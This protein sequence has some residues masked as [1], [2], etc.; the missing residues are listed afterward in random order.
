MQNEINL[1]SNVE[2]LK[3]EGQNQNNCDFLSDANLFWGPKTTSKSFY[4]LCEDLF[5]HKN[6]S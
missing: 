1:G 4:F 6:L 2:Q 3:L 5:E